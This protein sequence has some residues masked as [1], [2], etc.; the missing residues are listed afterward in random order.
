MTP[1]V[2]ETTV[3]CTFNDS[4]TGWQDTAGGMYYSKNTRVLCPLYM[5]ISDFLMLSWV[6]ELSNHGLKDSFWESSDD[7]RFFPKTPNKVTNYLSYQINLSSVTGGVVARSPESKAHVS[8]IQYEHS[9]SNW[10]LELLVFRRREN[11]SY[12]VYPKEKPLR[13]EKRTS[14]KLGPCD[15]TKS[16]KG[17]PGHI[18]GRWVLS[19]LHHPSAPKGIIKHNLL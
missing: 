15:N 10:N 14:N 16:G 2:E 5:T 6:V 8:N 17:T 4:F 13:A 3:A 11:R 7:F 1:V 19:P 9:S 12:R 18:G